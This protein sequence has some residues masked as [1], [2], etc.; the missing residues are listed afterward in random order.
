MMEETLTLDRRDML[1]AGAALILSACF[2]AAGQAR[3]FK[4]NAWLVITPDNRI[5]VFTETPEMGQGTRTAD[6]MALAEELEADW[7]TIQVEQ[8]PTD[9]GVY[10]NLTA[11]GSGSTTA[12]WMSMRRAG[13][14]AREIL[15]SAASLKW[16]VEKSELRAENGT[17]VHVPTGRRILYG[18]LVETAS[19][20]TPPNIDDIPLKKPNTFRFVGR[21]AARVDTR[22]KV[23]GSAI[24]GIDV[25]VPD[26]LFAVIARCPHF[27]GK[28]A[29]CNDTAAKAVPGVRAVFPV[30]SIV[31]RPTES[32][33]RTAGGIAVVADSTWAA[34]QGRKALQLTWDKG[35]AANENSAS[36]QTAFHERASAPPSYIPVNQGDA[37]KEL[38]AAPKKIEAL[39]ELP[40][41]AHATMEPMNTTVHIR[42]DGIEVWSPTQGGNVTQAEIAHLAG[43]PLNK[44]TVHVTLSGGSFG[45]RLQW[46]FPAEAWQVAKQVKRPV[47]LLFTR[48]D[49]MQH[50]FYRPYVWHQLSGSLDGD[51]NI[52]AWL[53]RLSSTAIHAYYGPASKLN[54]PKYVAAAELGCSNMIP[55]APRNFRLEYRPIDSAVPRA[56]WRS[57][58]M[59]PNAFATESF[60]DE[61]AH[62]SGRDP[63]EFRMYLLRD[64][65]KVYS[66]TDPKYFNETRKFRAVLQLAAEK[67]EWSKPLPKGRG[68]GI[69]C[70]VFGG[71]YIAQVAEVAMQ[72]DGSARVTRV[73]CAID[74]GMAINPDS[75][76]SQMEG[77]INYA[78]TTVLAGEITINEGAV[79]QSNFHDYKVLRM[80]E[81]PDIEVHIVP[82]AE[83]PA[84]GVG[85]G[86]VTPLAAAVANAIFAASGKRIRRFPD[87]AKI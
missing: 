76:R 85:E 11:G 4:P 2:P 24:F 73:V 48:E 34:I 18:E 47:Q 62:A 60:I 74:C 35:P 86:G 57:V 79:V 55:Y 17:I 14:Q 44:V 69:A 9:S 78:L 1:K 39:Y 41:Q 10:H 46:D 38:A 68:R 65:R 21:P 72:S 59:A 84:S 28:L 61:L 31:P 26:M 8:A 16:N 50:D 66:P 71:S 5:T 58:Q 83:E 23:E 12:N 51:G 20:L 6:M 45:R 29:A 40:F 30:L 63:Y 82:G 42:E 56:W 87:I 52:A 67:A 19:K 80:N 22:S 32:L 77:G 25:R 53:H 7:S 15:L 33:D 64:D 75:V 81:A 3:N 43:L 36:L 49:D 27:G 37:V 70:Y 54:D 13:A